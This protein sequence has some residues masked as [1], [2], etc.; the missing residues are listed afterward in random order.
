MTSEPEQETFHVFPKN[1]LDACFCGFHL[2]HNQDLAITWSTQ[3][4]VKN[5]EGGYPQLLMA[6]IVP[7]LH[8]PES[9]LV[10]TH[11]LVRVS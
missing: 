1:G 3:S 10:V 11:P 4:H 9:V 8:R 7:N 5:Q 6:G 2:S